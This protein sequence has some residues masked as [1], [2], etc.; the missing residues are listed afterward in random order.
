MKLTFSDYHT[1]DELTFKRLLLICDELAFFDAPSINIADNLGT[2][3]QKSGLRHFIKDFE[4]SPVKLIVDEPPNSTFNSGFYHRYFE[5]DLANKLFINTIFEGIEAGWIYDNLFDSGKTNPAGEFNDY[6]SW[7]LANREE[8]LATNLYE[9]ERPKE[10]WK[11]TNKHEAMFAFKIL[12]SSE[13]MSVTST[14]FICNKYNN[15][16]VS[17]S[18]YLNKLI[19]IRLTSD[20]YNG[21]P[22]KAR[23]LGLRLM[24]CFIPDEALLQISWQDILEFR[25]QAKPYYEAW[26]IEINKLEAIIFKEIDILSDQDILNL[27]DSEIN[28]RLLELKNEIR[29]VRDDRYKNIFKTIKNV[30]V[31]GI[32]LGT[33]SG[34]SIPGAIASFIGTNLKTPQLTDDII[35]SHFKLK[36]KQL[37]NGLTYLLKIQNLLQ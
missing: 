11:V 34:L 13:S 22:I 25:E 20:I 23:Q 24:D 16:P 31:S 33:L 3:G 14:L 10:V 5:K 17:I 6:K 37:S 7:I 2:V 36:D 15:A 35:D 32:A 27:I 30:L 19:S 1:T 29:R 26:N 28:P 18:P 4:G 21:K 8:I 9:I 12:A